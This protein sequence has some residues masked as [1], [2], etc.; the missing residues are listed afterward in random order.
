MADLEK[1][2]RE[3]L[4]V[5]LRQMN[6]YMS[7]VMVFWGGKEEYREIFSQVAGNEKGEYTDEEADNARIILESDG[8]FD[9]FVELVRTSFERGGINHVLSEKVSVLMEETASKYR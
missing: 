2:T 5:Q 1:M 7:N 4:I 8:A 6:E 3:E 9:A